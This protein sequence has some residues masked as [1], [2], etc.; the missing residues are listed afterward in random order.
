MLIKCHVIKLILNIDQIIQV[1]V[2]EIDESE[3]E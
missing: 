2:V 3:A 1:V